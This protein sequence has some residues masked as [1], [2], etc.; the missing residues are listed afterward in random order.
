MTQ[1]E[2]TMSVIPSGS[3]IDVMFDL[4]FVLPSVNPP[5]GYFRDSQT[6]RSYTPLRQR[7]SAPAP[8]YYQS[9]QLRWLY[10]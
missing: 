3:A 6:R 7:F 9:Y 10:L 2:Q 8:T 4:T 1:L 5:G